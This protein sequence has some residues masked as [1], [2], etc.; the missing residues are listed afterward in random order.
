MTAS[1]LG[2]MPAVLDQLADDVTVA[3]GNGTEELR[4]SLTTPAERF[5]NRA[6]VPAYYAVAVSYPQLEISPEPLARRS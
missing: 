4:L 6:G 5:R 2:G 3:T 1:A